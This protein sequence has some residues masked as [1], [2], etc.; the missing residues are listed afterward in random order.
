M[1]FS[2]VQ[3]L[4]V[5]F[6]AW[7]TVLG[8]SPVPPPARLAPYVSVE[9]AGVGFRYG[10]SQFGAADFRRPHLPIR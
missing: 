4:G 9:L 6:A 7:G 2:N 10:P 5:T 1:L 3:A 8:D